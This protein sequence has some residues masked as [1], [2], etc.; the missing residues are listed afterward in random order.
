MVR[1]GGRGYVTL[2]SALV[3][4]REEKNVAETEMV[5]LGERIARNT[6]RKLHSLGYTPEQ[7]S[8]LSQEIGDPQEI[9]KWVRLAPEAATS[10]GPLST[11]ALRARAEGW[12]QPSV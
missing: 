12:R 7:L 5:D 4:I 1:E 8:H 10:V 9:G 2:L 3:S 11:M 6:A